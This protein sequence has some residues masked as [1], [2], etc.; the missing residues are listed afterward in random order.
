LANGKKNENKKFDL[1]SLSE[2]ESRELDELKIGC[3]K[4]YRDLRKG[5]KFKDYD[6]AKLF[7]LQYLKNNVDIAN[8]LKNRSVDERSQLVDILLNDFEL[9]LT[10]INEEIESFDSALTL[11][12]ISDK[13]KNAGADDEDIKYFFNLK[14]E[15]RN[16]FLN[17]NEEDL[18]I[19]IEKLKEIRIKDDERNEALAQDE[20]GE[21][22]VRAGANQLD[23]DYF[24]SLDKEVRLDIINLG[25]SEFESRIKKL[26]K[27]R[28]I[29]PLASELEK[30]RQDY[31]K[32]EDEIGM[33]VLKLKNFFKN[34]IIDD[35]Y[36]I[37]KELEEYK[38]RYELAL[39]NYTQAIVDIEGLDD[40]EERE[41][42]FRYAKFGETLNLMD[43]RETIK[44][45]K[46]PYWESFKRDLGVGTLSL[47]DKY[48]DLLGKSR[49]FITEKT[50]SKLLGIGGGAIAVG[51]AMSFSAGFFSGIGYVARVM[52]IA[53][54]TKGFYEKAETE[55]FIKKE[56]DTKKYFVDIEGRYVYMDGL[57]SKIDEDF[58]EELNL[59][60]KN[61][62][63]SA[64][65]EREQE[66]RRILSS[67]GK[68]VLMNLAFYEMG[69]ILKDSGLIEEGMAM[70]KEYI[71]TEKIASFMGIASSSDGA[72]VHSGPSYP[73]IENGTPIEQNAKNM[74]DGGAVDTSKTVQDP[75][76]EAEKAPDKIGE[77]EESI[78]GDSNSNQEIKID[79]LEKE[80]IKDK[81]NGIE[82]NDLSRGNIAII[83]GKGIKDSV[84]SLL[85]QNSEK[86]TEGKMGWDPNKY[87]SVEEWANKRAIGIVAELKEKY[88]EYD[89][90]KVSVDSKIE[91]DLSNKADIKVVGFDDPKHLGGSQNFVKDLEEKTSEESTLNNNENITKEKVAPEIKKEVPQTDIE[92]DVL[93]M[94][95]EINRANTLKE[96]SVANIL[97]FKPAEYAELNDISLKQ[98][99][100]E[101]KDSGNPENPNVKLKN[102]FNFM[103]ENGQI[104]DMDKTISETIRGLSDQSLKDVIVGYESVTPEEY[105]V[106]INGLMRGEFQLGMSLN[107]VRG[108]FLNLDKIRDNAIGNQSNGEMFKLFKESVEKTG[109]KF[110][111]SD[112]DSVKSYVMKAM[113]KAYENGSIGRLREALKE[114]NGDIK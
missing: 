45:Q 72:K 38:E 93:K 47:V 43:A 111:Y 87:K 62:P 78:P 49:K 29:I 89:F 58:K 23:I 94:E 82:V 28:E 30:A 71:P 64:M 25:E 109:I 56:Q 51:G 31:L 15:D 105:N 96:V 84:A 8:E 103:I 114:I 52:G 9:K 37:E 112:N 16:D 22:L 90:D 50:S 10:Q 33:T 101:L 26:Q 77:T 11:E 14:R 91:V 7:I 6:E 63:E 75:A 69:K 68:A 21:R 106:F 70:I 107:G 92:K 98:L 100:G 83:E 34:I 36:E 5:G 59:I 88:P 60:I 41:I 19:R 81:F 17:S 27:D 97:G 74:N 3:E 110:G 55:A 76:M 39:K 4:L 66:V 13:L 2:N 54:A 67:F 86:L 24:Y 48:K 85:A 61:I 40:K 99:F 44:F 18:K 108:V 57:K 53:V 12:E 35:K 79:D 95:V 104:D 42:L 113:I 102:L 73:P 80:V 46:S 65:Q 1:N 32:K 20:L